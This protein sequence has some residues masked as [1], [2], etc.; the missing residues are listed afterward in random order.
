MRRAN[1]PRCGDT[2]PHL[3]F[4]GFAARAVPRAQG[5]WGGENIPAYWGALLKDKKLQ[6]VLEQGEH[7][8]PVHSK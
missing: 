4:D 6:T 8:D 2:G 7:V 5:Y 1:I 3:V